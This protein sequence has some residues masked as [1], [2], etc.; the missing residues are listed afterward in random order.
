MTD[1]NKPENEQPSDLEQELNQD[2]LAE[3]KEK[4]VYR[5]LLEIVVIAVVL[6]LILRLFIITPYY[7]PSESMLPALEID[8]KI[9]VSRLNYYF[10]EPQRG[11]V[12]VF[13]Y[14]RNPKTVFV[15]RCIAVGGETV[16]G[17]DSVL[18]INGE[19]VPEQYLP[20]DLR[21]ANFGP[22]VVP[23]DNYFMLGDNRNNS[24]DSRS[25]G[26]VEKKLLI[27][28]AVVRIWPFDRAGLVR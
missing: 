12:V 19:A 5:E 13:H 20:E 6:A 22:T 15:K 24:D 25:W 28:K 17:K 3:S 26:F 11:E 8:D 14:P 18:Y 10:K 9:L 4:S 16:E 7:I 1:D 23:Q 2:V 27:G 21:F